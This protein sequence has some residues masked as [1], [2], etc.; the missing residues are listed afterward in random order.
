MSLL[1]RNGSHPRSDGSHG[2][3]GLSSLHSQAL[4]GLSQH[5]T[6]IHTLRSAEADLTGNGEELIQTLE[7]TTLAVSDPVGLEVTEQDHLFASADLRHIGRSDQAVVEQ[8]V[9][10]TLLQAGLPQVLA[11]AILQL[12]DGL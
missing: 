7:G 10:L 3:L 2:R 9:G 12:P 8:G 11:L 6:A 5:Q 1:Q 4:H